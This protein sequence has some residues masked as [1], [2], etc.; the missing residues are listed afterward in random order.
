MIDKFAVVF[1]RQERIDLLRFIYVLQTC[2]QYVFHSM[3][4][5][6]ALIRREMRLEQACFEYY[7]QDIAE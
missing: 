1:L 5:S 2:F 3:L 6:D 4:N 7:I